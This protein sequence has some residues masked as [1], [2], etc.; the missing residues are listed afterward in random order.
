MWNIKG[1]SSSGSKRAIGAAS[2]IFTHNFAGIDVRKIAHHL[3]KAVIRDKVPRY[4]ERLLVSNSVDRILRTQTLK[5]PKIAAHD[6][7]H[8]KTIGST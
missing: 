5:I 3:T 2:H 6:L 4:S 1:Q 8:G 7:S